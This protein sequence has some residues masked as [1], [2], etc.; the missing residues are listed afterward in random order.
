M[1][2]AAVKA[3]EILELILMPAKAI[4]AKRQNKSSFFRRQTRIGD[5][6]LQFHGI[7]KHPAASRKPGM[8]N[9]QYEEECLNAT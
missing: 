9:Q 1:H 6:M 8:P 5:L 3:D 4:T 2:A 7:L